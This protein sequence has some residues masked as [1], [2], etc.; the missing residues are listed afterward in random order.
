MIYQSEI[1]FL[2]GDLSELWGGEEKILEVLGG[3]IRLLGRNIRGAGGS[4]R[5]LRGS[6]RTLGGSIR[7]HG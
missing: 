1:R 4:I 3:N 7:D 5:P 2:E 6:I